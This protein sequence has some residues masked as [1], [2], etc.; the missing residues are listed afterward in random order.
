M[1]EPIDL[2]E[3]LTEDGQLNAIVPYRATVVLKPS[4]IHSLDHAET[5]ETN[6][7]R[8]VLGEMK[9]RGTKSYVGRVGSSSKSSVA[10]KVVDRPPLVPFRIT[11]VRDASGVELNRVFPRIPDGVTRQL[12]GDKEDVCVHWE[13]LEV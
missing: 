8:L 10:D 4:D 7:P 3:F 12:V 13:V 2:N 9:N 5:V 1:V 11:P 6:K